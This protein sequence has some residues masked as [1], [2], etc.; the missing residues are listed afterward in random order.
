VRRPDRVDL[1]S[2]IKRLAVAKLGVNELE[3]AALD[4]GHVDPK[5]GK[6]RP[7]IPARELGPHAFQVGKRD[8]DL[9]RART[10]DVRV[11]EHDTVG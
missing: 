2:R 10:R 6:I 4:L 7:V 11:G 3:P 1:L 8:V 5:H 9:D